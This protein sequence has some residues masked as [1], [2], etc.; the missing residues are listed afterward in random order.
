VLLL[1]LL[2]QALLLLPFRAVLSLGALV[3]F[4]HQLLDANYGN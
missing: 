4:G 2:N 1:E 3:W